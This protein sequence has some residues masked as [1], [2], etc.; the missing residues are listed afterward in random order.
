MLTNF[1]LQ[2]YVLGNVTVLA[3]MQEH[4]TRA[5]RTAATDAEAFFKAHD[6]PS[7]LRA[8]L[9]AAMQLRQSDARDHR[10]VMETFPPVLR[11]KCKRLLYLPLIRDVYIFERTP[12]TFCSVLS[13]MLAVDLFLPG[14]TILTRNMPVFDLYIITS[15]AVEFVL[16]PSSDKIPDGADGS[17]D[18]H[19]QE[20]SGDEGEDG[21]EAD[22]A[23]ASTE[24]P[25]DIFSVGDCFGEVAYL[26]RLVQPF[27]VRARTLTRT[28]ALNRDSWKL[29]LASRPDFA[30]L[31]EDAVADRLFML[32]KEESELPWSPY[33]E[34]AR[35]VREIRARAAEAAA[36]CK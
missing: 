11:R 6:L 19:H 17:L 28:L 34:L 29:V 36:G 3:T 13:T 12:H 23:A 10:E 24:P 25:F 20:F 2:A 30:R 21:E 5:F 27:A 15:G 1:A 26:F 14:T 18:D 22:E 33:P 7:G 16:P 4:S 35:E 9:R 8:S 31:V 32:A